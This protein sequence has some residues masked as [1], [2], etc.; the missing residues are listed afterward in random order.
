MRVNP[1]VFYS[2]TYG[3]KNFKHIKEDS[4]YEKNEVKDLGSQFVSRSGSLSQESPLIWS[5]PYSL[6]SFTMRSMLLRL[7]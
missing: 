4:I 2:E 7:L 6:S 1:Y 3:V 5:P